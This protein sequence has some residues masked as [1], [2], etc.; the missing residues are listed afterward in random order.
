MKVLLL[1]DNIIE[2]VIDREPG[3]ACV[4]H[5]DKQYYWLALS[6]DGEFGV[7]TLPKDEGK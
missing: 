7:A 2:H 1:K 4:I 3:A 5:N 6:L